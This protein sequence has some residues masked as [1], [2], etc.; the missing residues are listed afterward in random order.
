MAGEARTERGIV[1]RA[2]LVRMYEESGLDSAVAAR[3]AEH[4]LSR[5]LRREDAAAP[6]PGPRRPLSA[7]FVRAPLDTLA[8]LAGKRDGQLPLV[9]G[10][11]GA[12]SVPA[13]A[14]VL[15][16]AGLEP[17]VALAY[18]KVVVAAYSPEELYAPLWALLGE[19]GPVDLEALR[20]RDWAAL[21][22]R[23]EGQG[24]D[25]PGSEGPLLGASA[26]EGQ[27]GE[28]T[29]VD[30]PATSGAAELPRSPAA[31][32]ER[33][34]ETGAGRSA[35]A[36]LNEAPRPGGTLRRPGFGPRKP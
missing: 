13:I 19:R 16:Q 18:A 2:W 24:G 4:T 6:P 30:Q 11:A 21:R 1:E 36:A 25:L 7:S 5:I 20:R 32:V 9:D 31:A 23:A 29:L 34:K 10:L 26:G 35:E 28:G 15:E 17:I 22:A 12:L 27:R 3:A 8:R 14:Q 33:A